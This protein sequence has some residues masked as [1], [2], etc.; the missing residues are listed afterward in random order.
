MEHKSRIELVISTVD[1]EEIYREI[2]ESEITF[3][4]HLAD[5]QMMKNGVYFWHCDMRCFRKGVEER[6]VDTG[7]FVITS[8]CGKTYTA[9]TSWQTTEVPK[10]PNPAFSILKC[11][12][13]IEEGKE[14]KNY[15]C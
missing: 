14:V 6:I 13:D 11:S 2:A 8:S 7:F 12:I 9:A 5:G 15:V 10:D 3:T 4:G 1:G